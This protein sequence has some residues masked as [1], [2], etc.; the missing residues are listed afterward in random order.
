MG[1]TYE[2][3]L[4][5]AGRQFAVVVSRFNSFLSEQLLD[6]ALDGLRRHGVA[7][8][9]ISVVRV[10]G[11]F[12][13]P[14]VAMRLARSGSF[15]AIICLGVV[16]RGATP[17]FDYVAGQAASGIARV[18]LETGV[19]TLFGV[20]TTDTIEQAIERCGAKS[21]NKGWDA[22]MS[23]IEMADLMSVLPAAG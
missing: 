3:K 14:A 17:H 6:G 19:P 1:K 13:L 8:D 5:G 21:S 12:E 7:D 9:A 10:P 22:A 11:A 4:S 18:G 23:A 20:V 15:E 2:G 16:I